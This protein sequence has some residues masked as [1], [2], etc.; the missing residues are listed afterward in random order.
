MAPKPITA[1]DE[2]AQSEIIMQHAWNAYA[3]L[4]GMEMSVP[5]LRDNPAWRIIVSDAFVQFHEAYEA[6][7]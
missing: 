2:S 1:Q 5:E 4:R 6:T 7:L 3:A